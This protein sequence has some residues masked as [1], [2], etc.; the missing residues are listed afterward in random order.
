LRQST[1]NL[2]YQGSKIFG[3]TAGKFQSRVGKLHNN[4]FFIDDTKRSLRPLDT[5]LEK[6][7]F[8]L[9]DKFIPGFWGH[10]AI[11]IGNEIQLKKLNLWNHPKVKMY[12]KQIKSGQTIVEALSFSIVEGNWHPNCKM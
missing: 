7:P 5:L 12:H 8:R 1:L 9:T 2:L 11:Y 3:N 6:T 4:N 10:A